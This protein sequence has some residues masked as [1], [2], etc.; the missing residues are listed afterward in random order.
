MLYGQICKI[1]KVCVEFQFV[2][3]MVIVEL[4]LGALVYQLDDCRRTLSVS[5]AI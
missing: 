5:S 2:S 3:F 1:G 4:C